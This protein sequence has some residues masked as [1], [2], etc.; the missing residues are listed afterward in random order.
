MERK[1]DKDN[2]RK[3]REMKRAKCVGYITVVVSSRKK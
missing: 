1:S 2:V 3:E